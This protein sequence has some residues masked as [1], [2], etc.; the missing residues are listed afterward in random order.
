MGVLHSVPDIL[1]VISSV[2]SLFTISWASSGLWFTVREQI[3]FP[4]S[5]K[6]FQISSLLYYLS[7]LFMLSGRLIAVSAFAASVGLLPLLYVLLAHAC[8]ALITDV[9]VNW[10]HPERSKL[11]RENVVPRLVE[12]FGLL[13]DIPFSITFMLGPARIG[14]YC[15]WALETL[16]LDVFAFCWL[17]RRQPTDAPT[18]LEASAGLQIALLILVVI[19]AI[20]GITLRY[21]HFRQELKDL[22]TLDQNICEFGEMLKQNEYLK[23]EL[24]LA[25]ETCKKAQDSMESDVP[26]GQLIVNSLH[27]VDKILN[28]SVTKA[29]A[30]ATKLSA[31][32]FAKELDEDL[33]QIQMEAKDFTEQFTS[34]G[35]TEDWAVEFIPIPFKLS[36]LS[37]ELEDLSFYFQLNS[38][39][40]K[41]SGLGVYQ[42]ILDAFAANIFVGNECLFVDIMAPLVNDQPKFPHLFFKLEPKNVLQK[43]SFAFFPVNNCILDPH[44]RFLW[45]TRRDAFKQFQADII[46]DRIRIAEKEE[47]MPKLSRNSKL[48]SFSRFTRRK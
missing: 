14:C 25:K 39:L 37:M 30:I 1:T 31:V 33:R 21:L 18:V 34:T 11:S 12:F 23:E 48:R 24:R 19:F 8:I 29:S 16:L 43:I 36:Q 27:E 5:C 13:F 42:K 22:R 4:C 7:N 40:H 17:S 20:A 47:L 32:D 6:L 46:E 41:T 45:P 28:E 3:Y 26:D 2:F 9:S 44:T 38:R 15:L 10:G 35:V